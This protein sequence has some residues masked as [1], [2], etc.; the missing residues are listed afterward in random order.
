VLFL[1]RLEQRGLGLR[2]RAVDFVGEDDLREDGAG[3]EGELAAA[4]F[5]V[6]LDD[7]GAGDVGGHQIGRELDAAEAEVHRIGE[8]FDEERL[9]K[10][11]HAFEQAVTTGGEGD[12]ELL[13]DGLLSDNAPA[14]GGL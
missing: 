1:H 11:G 13:N 6:F 10:A 7:L 4:G 5:G 14:E 3:L 2:R 9:R 12:E 8:R